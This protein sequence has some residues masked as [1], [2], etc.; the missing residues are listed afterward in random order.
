MNTNE[1]IGLIIVSLGSILGLAFTVAKPILDV[2]KT[3]TTLNE[4]IKNLTDKFTVFEISN[5]EA[6]K[7]IWS[8]NDEQDEQLQDH[9]IRIKLME[10][11]N[12]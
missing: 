4:S 6:H 11:R 8:H 2:T 12:K 7:R 3:M 9:E 1:M 5:L 10:D